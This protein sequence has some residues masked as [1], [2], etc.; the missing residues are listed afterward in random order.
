MVVIERGALLEIREAQAQSLVVF[1]QGLHLVAIGDLSRLGKVDVGPPAT[2]SKAGRERERECVCAGVERSKGSRGSLF[3][4][5]EGTNAPVRLQQAHSFPQV[6][7]GLVVNIEHGAL[8]L[9]HDAAVE[10]ATVVAASPTSLDYRVSVL[11]SRPCVV[12]YGA[13]PA[14]SNGQ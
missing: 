7:H 1:L 13:T 9:L 2:R 8:S 11:A 12:W 6:L 5:E 10:R 14:A 4:L 3:A